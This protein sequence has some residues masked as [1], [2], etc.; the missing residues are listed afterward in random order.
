MGAACPNVEFADFTDGEE[1]PMNTMPEPMEVAKTEIAELANCLRRTVGK[2]L[3]TSASFADREAM[4]LAVAHEVVRQELQA[5][6]Q[7]IADG[8][9]DRVRIEGVLY[10]EHEE[11]AVAYHSLAG[12]LQ[13]APGLDARRISQ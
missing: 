1:A 4:A 3:T 5:E 10:A 8:F 7:Q 13:E 9:G 2:L 6:L 11:G 12:D